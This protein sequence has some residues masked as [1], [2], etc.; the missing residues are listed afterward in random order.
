[1]YTKRQLSIIISLAKKYN[2]AI[3]LYSNYIKK[4]NEWFNDWLIIYESEPIIKE[5]RNVNN[6][7]YIC[8]NEWERDDSVITTKMD[9]T[10]YI[11]YKK[12]DFNY[13]HYEKSNFN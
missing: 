8:N 11:H 12:L 5:E 13:I 10:K 2:D 4:S 3:F 7:L 1:M 6:V 9:K